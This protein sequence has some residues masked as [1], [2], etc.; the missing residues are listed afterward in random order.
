MAFFER[1]LA[2][3]KQRRSSRALQSGAG[4]SR[5]LAEGL[6]LDGA[7]MR[8]TKIIALKQ[9]NAGRRQ[10]LELRFRL[11]A[12]REDL[13]PQIG[14][15]SRQPPHDRLPRLA[16]VDA[17]Q[18]LHVDLDKVGLKFGEQSQS[19]IAR[20]EI[21]ERGQEAEF[22]IGGDDPANVVGIPH[23]F[24]FG[25]FEHQAGA[26]KAGP[27][28]G[29]QGRSDA[30]RRLIDC[31]GHEIDRQLEIRAIEPFGRLFNRHD[32][33]ELVELV[34][35]RRRH[36]RQDRGGRLAVEAAH[37]RFIAPHALPGRV[38]YRLEGDLEIEPQRL[39]IATSKT[40]RHRRSF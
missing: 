12:F 3:F 18:N 1:P 15:D 28:G 17:A 16:V 35:V 5:R 22:A 6:A 21:V 30:G 4:T 24:V 37:E 36:A 29:G 33:A 34:A 20:A 13:N 14:G 8:A 32:A 40:L 25:E 31:I 11:H 9:P 26:I 2:F 7:H 38:D 27:I 19:R 10:G 23:G 39:I